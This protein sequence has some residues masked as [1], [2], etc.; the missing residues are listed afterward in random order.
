VKR[1]CRRMRRRGAGVEGERR[2]YN[3]GM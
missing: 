2:W 3:I 1:G